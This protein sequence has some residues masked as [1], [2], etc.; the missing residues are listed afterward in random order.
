M[1]NYSYF[2]EILELPGNIQRSD[3]QFFTPNSDQALSLPTGMAWMT[4]LLSFFLY[5]DRADFKFM[6][7]PGIYHG[8][9]NYGS[10]SDDL[11]DAAQLLPYPSSTQ[12]PISPGHDA[13]ISSQIPT[14]IALTEFHFILLYKDHIA[15]I[16][17]LDEKLTYEEIIPLVNIA[18]VHS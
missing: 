11:I 14:A 16:C 13:P 2:E 3:L 7:A 9:L 18:L 5:T 8:A 4:G 10:N 15:G 6:A 17:N 12:P 1:I